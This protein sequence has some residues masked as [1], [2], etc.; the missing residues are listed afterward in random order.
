MSNR[1]CDTDSEFPTESLSSELTPV[2]DGAA[3]RIESGSRTKKTTG[4]QSSSREMVRISLPCTQAYEEIPFARGTLSS[5]KSCTQSTGNLETFTF[6]TRYW[7]AS[8]VR[9]EALRS[10]WH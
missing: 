9:S 2:S 1:Q 7:N 5:T 6:H 10:N 8:T 4:R 3:L